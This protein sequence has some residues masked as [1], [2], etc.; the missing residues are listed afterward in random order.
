MF[1]I[2]VREFDVDGARPAHIASLG[3]KLSSK[4]CVNNEDENEYA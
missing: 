2:K 1:G 4:E 3:V